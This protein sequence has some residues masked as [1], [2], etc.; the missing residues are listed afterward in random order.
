MSVRL[1][2]RDGFKNHATQENAK[3]GIIQVSEI[4]EKSDYY[5]FGLKQGGDDLPDYSAINKYKYAY[6]GK[7][8]ND[9]LGLDLYDFGARNYDPA[10][11]RWLNIDPLAEVSRRWTPYNYAYNNPIYFVDPDGRLSGSFNNGYFNIDIVQFGGAMESWVGGFQTEGKD[12]VIITGNLTQE[13]FNSLQNSVSSELQLTI[14]KRGLVTAKQ[15]SDGELSQG[16]ADL[17]AATKDKSITVNID[18]DD[19]IHNKDT[20]KPASY[21]IGGSLM[22]VKYNEDGSVSTNQSVQ[23]I[24]LDKLDSANGAKRGHSILHETTESYEAGKLAQEQGYG[25]YR[26]ILNDIFDQ[27]SLYFR[28]HNSVIPPVGGVRPDFILDSNSNII[29]IDLYTGERGDILF[30]QIDVTKK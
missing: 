7:E 3:D 24:I 23:P 21:R 15:I 30:H 28:A 12:E 26:V 13:A 29:R 25:V 14:N 20:R 16:A 27:N 17:L 18:A 1:T 8:F 10:L 4:I 5:P 2:Y 11:G 22:S 9:E 6:G 19:N